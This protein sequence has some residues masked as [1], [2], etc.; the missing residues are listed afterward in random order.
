MTAQDKTMCIKYEGNQNTWNRKS[1]CGR[2]QRKP[3]EEDKVF[4]RLLEELKQDHNQVQEQTEE[5]KNDE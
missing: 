2:L 4:K 5:K 1:R 3:E